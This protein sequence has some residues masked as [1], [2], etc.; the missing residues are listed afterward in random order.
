MFLEQIQTFGDPFFFVVREGETLESVRK[1]IQEKLQI[2]D[3]DFANV[4]CTKIIYGW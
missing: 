4:R 1:R 2:S 3:A